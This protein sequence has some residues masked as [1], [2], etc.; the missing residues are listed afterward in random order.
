M[1]VYHIAPLLSVVAILLLQAEGIGQSG[2]AAED[3]VK[4]AVAEMRQLRAN[5]PW[6]IDEAKYASP[7]N[8]IGEIGPN[9]LPWLVEE[10]RHEDNGSLRFRLGRY[11]ESMARFELYVYSVEP[12]APGTPKYERYYDNSP[13]D[14]PQYSLVVSGQKVVGWTDDVVNTVLSWWDKCASAATVGATY[15]TIHSI[16]GGTASEF[17]DF[18]WARQRMFNKRVNIYGIFNLPAYI[19]A[20][21]RDNNPVVF[22]DFLRKYRIELYRQLEPTPDFPGNARLAQ[23]AYRTREEKLRIVCDWWHEARHTFT[24]LH[25]LCAAIDDALKDH[26]SF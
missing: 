13:E 8:R 19:T 17:E 21:V 12:D 25:Q 7:S 16:C 24:D 15:E 26:C 18:D 2:N 3:I 11:I 9:A 1:L 10:L 4:E 5:D 22:C 23:K 20:I 6:D 14:V